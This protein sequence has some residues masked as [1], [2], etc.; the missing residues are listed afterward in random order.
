MSANNPSPRRAR[1]FWRLWLSGAFGSAGD[2]SSILL[3]PSGTHIATL[4]PRLAT[5][6]SDTST[7]G[8]PSTSLKVA[9]HFGKSWMAIAIRGIAAIMCILLAS[10]A[11]VVVPWGLPP[12]A[13]LDEM[14]MILPC[15]CPA[16]IYDRSNLL[17]YEPRSPCYPVSVTRVTGKRRDNAHGGQPLYRS[18][19][20]RLRS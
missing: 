18:A 13:P 19:T 8:I 6:L 9:R 4:T 7:T 3:P 10:S 20:G 2:M 11:C 16:I 1:N 17:M 12:D 15:C 5:L 14:F